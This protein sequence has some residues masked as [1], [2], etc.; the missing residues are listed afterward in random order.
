M[1]QARDSASQLAC[2]R[3]Q[4]RQGARDHG[5]TVML[6]VLSLIWGVSWPVMKVALD[7]IPP[8]SMRVAT[9]GLGALTLVA[10]TTLQRRRIGIS[11]PGAWLHLVVASSLNIVGYSLLASFAQLGAT[12]SRVAVLVYTMPIWAALLARPV[13]GERITVIRAFALA[14]CAA[15]LTVLLVPFLGGGIPGGM[16]LAVGAGASWAAGTVYLKWARIDADP[17]AVTTWQLVIAFLL[18]GASLPLFEGAPHLWPVHAGALLA[19][20]FTGVIAVGIAYMLWFEIVR[21]LPATTAALGILSVPALGVLSSMFMLGER[22]TL[23]DAAGFVLIISAAGCVLVL[24]N[25]R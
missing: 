17:L 5:A 23:A 18:I 13:L 8:F 16:L 10:V 14:L 19:L 22:P 2:G 4:T 11:S 3:N 7:E 20:L 12:T 9:A 15:G 25:K 24:E 6:I 1:M 21:R